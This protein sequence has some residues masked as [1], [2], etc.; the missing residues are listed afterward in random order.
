MI[1]ELKNLENQ[2]VMNIMKHFKDNFIYSPSILPPE[3]Q[4]ETFYSPIGEKD[5]FSHK[6]I[7]MHFREVCLKFVY[8]LNHVHFNPRMQCIAMKLIT[9]DYFRFSSRKRLQLRTG[10]YRN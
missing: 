5:F 2:L 10:I 9:F 8:S 7:Q 1:D 4:D 6:I 3:L